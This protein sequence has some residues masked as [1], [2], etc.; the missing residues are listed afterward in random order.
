MRLCF[1]LIEAITKQHV[2]YIPGTV[3]HVP[4]TR[5]ESLGAGIC[6]YVFVK[7]TL[8]LFYLAIV[9]KEQIK[10]IFQFLR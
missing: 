9:D 3:H 2:V 4:G 10:L 8:I 1:F 6:K 5:F 7:I